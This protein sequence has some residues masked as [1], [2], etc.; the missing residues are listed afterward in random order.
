MKQTTIVKRSSDD[1]KI[2]VL[3][4]NEVQLGAYHDFLVKERE[5]VV[6]KIIEAEKA[7]KPQDQPENP[8]VASN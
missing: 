5:W 3:I 8:D 2:Q 4:E 7:S 6:E 1:D